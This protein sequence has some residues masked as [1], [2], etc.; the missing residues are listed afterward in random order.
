MRHAPTRLPAPG[1]PVGNQQRIPIPATPVPG[2][3]S[4]HFP[5]GSPEN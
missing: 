5:D 2:D 3:F 4:V 1:A